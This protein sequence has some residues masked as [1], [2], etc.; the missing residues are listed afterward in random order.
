[1]I[2]YDTIRQ[3]REQQHWTQ[4]EMA[5][6]LGMSKNGY[7]KIERGESLPNLSR[8]EQIAAVLGVDWFYLLKTSDKSLIV[9]T[10]NHNANYHINH[11][12]SGDKL[13]AE[14]ERLQLIVAHKNEIIAQKDQY[15]QTLERLLPLINR[16]SGAAQE[17]E[18]LIKL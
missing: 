5:E 12:A 8:L 11:Y 14:I 7:A 3:L 10:Q 6:R 13:Q 18:E 2:A 4:E 15:I 1:M 17:A 9:Q 16:P